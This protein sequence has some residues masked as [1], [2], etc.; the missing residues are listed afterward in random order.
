VAVLV[1]G[2]G[3]AAWFLSGRWFQRR[4]AEEE[5]QWRSDDERLGDDEDDP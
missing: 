2:A 4:V 5:E 1:V 3:L